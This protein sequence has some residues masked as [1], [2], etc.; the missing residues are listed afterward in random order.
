MAT[1]TLLGSSEQAHYSLDL[2]RVPVRLFAT[3]EQHSGREQLRT[4]P[5]PISTGQL[6]PLLGF[7]IRPIN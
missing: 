4:S 5:R 7:H 2:F 6:H 1:E 3:R